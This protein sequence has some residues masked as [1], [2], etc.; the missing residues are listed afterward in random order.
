MQQALPA[1]PRRT[2]RAR[3]IYE[4][5]E[6]GTAQQQ[7]DP[8]GESTPIMGNLQSRKQQMTPSLEVD[9]LALCKA[10]A[11]ASLQLPPMHLSC[12]CQ[13]ETLC[14]GRGP[15]PRTR[16]RQVPWQ[17]QLA[18]GGGQGGCAGGIHR[19]W[20]APRKLRGAMLEGQAPSGCCHNVVGG[21]PRGAAAPEP[22]RDSGFTVYGL[23]PESYRVYRL[24]ASRGRW[25]KRPMSGNF[26]PYSF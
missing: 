21:P 5:A 26:R 16:A 3:G 20:A 13:L 14:R 7:A 4:L 15:R 25:L 22:G 9:T 8:A 10:D 2:Q 11:I 24:K 18:A 17:R 6:P 1:H 23:K 12:M 19:I